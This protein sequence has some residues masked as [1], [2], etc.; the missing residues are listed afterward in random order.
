MDIT[1]ESG[2]SE[3]AKSKLS[4]IINSERE[5][6]RLETGRAEWQRVEVIP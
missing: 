1:E 5:N 4:K 3:R 6:L 2:Q